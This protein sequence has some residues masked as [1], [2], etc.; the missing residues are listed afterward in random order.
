M[1]NK[2]CVVSNMHPS[3]DLRIVAKE[4]PSLAKK[5]ET[6]LL[7]GNVKDEIIGNLHIVGV[8]LPTSRMKRMIT[9][10]PVLKKM[11]EIDADVYHFE[12]PEL[13]P[14]RGKLQKLGK[15]VIFDSHENFEELILTKIW[16][17]RIIRRPL[18]WLFGKYQKK[19]LPKFDAVISVTPFIVDRF[20]KYNPNTYQVTNYPILQPFHDNRKWRKSVCFAGAIMW[21]WMHDNIIES[22]GKTDAKYYLA[23]GDN[24]E[25]FEKLKSLK[26]WNKVEYV[27]A[28]PHDKV[29]DFLQQHSA[30]MHVSSYN[31]PNTGYKEGTLGVNKLFE[32]MGAGVPIITSAHK[33]WKEIIDKYHCGICV[34]P[35]DSNDIADAINTLVNN[36]EQAKQMG[37]NAR[38]AAEQEFN[39]GEQEK[40]LYD[41][42]DNLLK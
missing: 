41:I 20:K 29:Q 31:D 30:A 6:Y 19:S 36:P 3:Y 11:I 42:Y 25:Y 34:D 10:K 21:E 27:G 40:I 32:Y 26:N 35:E 8:K 28:L 39:W 38:K 22:L 33:V 5:Y 16:I 1:K 2:V 9:L 7:M 13:L 23:G 17:P 15:K 12:D 24:T 18:S 14:L 37:D 4:A